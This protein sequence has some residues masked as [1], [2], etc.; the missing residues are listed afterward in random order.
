MSEAPLGAPGP[1]DT[2]RSAVPTRS[3]AGSQPLDPAQ[4]QENRQAALT[5]G[6]AA[7]IVPDDKDWTW[8][9]E[10]PCP[11]CGFVAGEIGSDQVAGLVLA[12]AAPWPE[13]LTRPDVR[14]RPSPRTWSVLEYGC[15]VR[16]VC[17]VFEGRVA[18]MLGEDSP[19]FDNWDQDAAA[20]A[21]RYDL[22]DPATVAADLGQAADRLA[23][24]FLGVPAADWGR[25][26]VRS[27][28]SRFTV[29][30]LGRYVL[31]DLRHH[32]HDVDAPPS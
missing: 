24:A 13:L 3:P 25:E 6:G 23:R 21:A 9:L 5:P 20:T 15:H 29:L 26:G 14:E 10:R 19:T 30:T 28:G 18:L 7:G 2:T 32:L 4:A 12:L 1:L 8:V 16:D 17:R 27:N 11:D 31:H 22:Q